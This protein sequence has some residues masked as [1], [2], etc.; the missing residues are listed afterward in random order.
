MHTIAGL[1]PDADLV[2]VDETGCDPRHGFRRRGWSPLGVTPVQIA[3]FQR[4]QR[5]H[6]LPAYRTDGIV[7]AKV[8]KGSTDAAVF[9]KFIEELLPRLGPHSV[10]I[11]DNASFHHS[12]NVRWM[13]EAAG[14][15]LI[16][17]PPYSPDLNPIE[18]F[19]ADLKARIKRE[20][21]AYNGISD[22][23]FCAFLEW[24]VEIVG[25]NQE[26][27]QAHFRH[28]GYSV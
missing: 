23:D 25:R 12:E 14:I 4:S 5:Y 13:C 3:R 2:F 19:F 21:A 7:Y 1:D 6:I 28:A 11:M 17:L 8:Y 27:A 26:G 22:R 9:E 18:E 10:L 20:W 15:K 24:C 16:F